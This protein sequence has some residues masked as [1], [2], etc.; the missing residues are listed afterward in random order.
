MTTNSVGR[1]NRIS[2]TVMIAG[3]RAAF[4]SARIIR[5]WRN[6]ADSTRSARGERSAVFLGLDHGRDDAAHRF[7]IDAVGEV[8]ERLAALVEEAELDRGQPELVAE[9][10]IGLAQLPGDAAERGIDGEAGFGADD[11]QVERVGQDP[12]GSRGCAC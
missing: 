2:G 11:Q 12:C 9:L 4:S 6:S 1:M 3:R 7:E 8:L 10:G 5:W